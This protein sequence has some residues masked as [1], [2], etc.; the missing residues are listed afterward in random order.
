[1]KIADKFGLSVLLICLALAMPLTASAQEQSKD[2]AAQKLALFEKQFQNEASPQ[3]K[4]YLLT[5][6]ASAALAADDT[7]KAQ[8]YARDLLKQAE[9][10]KENWNYGNAIHVG[11]LVLGLTALQSG[12]VS[13]AK[14]YLLEAGKTPG[15][16]QLNSFGPNMRLAK[17]LLEK[18]EREVVIQYFEF[19]AKFWEMHKD[20]LDAWTT[21]VKAGQIPN[22]GANLFYQL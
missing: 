8:T 21:Q 15:S 17:E 7:D 3:K 1:M 19:C 22:F 18:S 4:F 20:R 16:P 13:Q 9:E 5:Q 2:K 14:A 11:N 12:D 10:Q 6:L